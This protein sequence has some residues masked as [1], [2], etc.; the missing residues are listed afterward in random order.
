[1][2][3]NYKLLAAKT[4]KV[5]NNLIIDATLENGQ[6]VSAF[7]GALEIASICKKGTKIWL[8]RTSRKN[9]L[10][11]YNVSFVEAPEGLIFAN[12]RYSRTLFKE[13]FEQGLLPELGGY[14]V[15]TP[16]KPKDNNNGLDFE[17]KAPDGHT[18]FVFVTS[19]YL[20]QDGCAVFPNAIN[21]FEL[22]MLDEMAKCRANGAKTY[23]FMIAPRQ[24]CA[25][26]K[27]VWNLNPQAAASMFDAAKNGLNFLCYGCNLELNEIKIG[28]KLEILY[29]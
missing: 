20:K 17:L 23:V 4:E 2:D 11:K 5:Y 21:F 15:C 24:D 18:A 7:C 27:F 6:K 12:P 28:P 19:L 16:L 26:A 25:N 13:A 22:K 29:K 14:T 3:Y 1:M 8:K 9:R 10:I